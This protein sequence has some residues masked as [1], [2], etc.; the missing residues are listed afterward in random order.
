MTTWDMIETIGMVVLL[1]L[2]VCWVY[3]ADQFD[4]EEKRN[5]KKK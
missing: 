3:Q 1:G 2:F 4:R 5:R